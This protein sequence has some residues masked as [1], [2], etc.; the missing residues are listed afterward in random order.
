MPKKAEKKK[1]AWRKACREKVKQGLFNDPD[2]KWVSKT[3]LKN[4]RMAE[5]MTAGYHF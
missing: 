2:G 1:K 3:G 4:D 5:M